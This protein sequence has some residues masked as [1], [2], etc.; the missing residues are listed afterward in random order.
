MWRNKNLP[1]FGPLQ[2]V[3]VVHATFSLAGPFAAQMLAD[4][5]ADVIW[6][7]NPLIPDVQRGVPNHTAE[8]ERRNQR[9]IALNIPSELGKNVFLKLLEGAAVFIENSK[10]GQYVRWGLSDEVLWQVNPSLVIC[11]ISGFGQTG[12][13]DYVH[14]ASFDSIAQAFSG[15]MD[16]NTEEGEVPRVIGPYQGDYTTG[17]FAV[18]GILAAL[19]RV[20]QTGK[21][22]S[23]DLAQYEALM[24]TQWEAIEAL[25]F[26]IKPVKASTPDHLVGIGAYLCQDGRYIELSIVGAAI[27]KKACLLIGVPYGTDTFPEG[28]PMVY[29]HSPAEQV[30]L[31]KLNAFLAARSAAQAESEFLAAG[32]AATQVNCIADLKDNP[33]IVARG[34]IEHIT[35][36]KG[37]E[38]D[39]VGTVPRFAKNPC[40]TWRP[41]PYIGMDNEEILTELGFGPDEIAQL[42]DKRVVVNDEDMRIF[43]P[44]DR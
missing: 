19:Y 5:G 33:H 16:V 41:M 8:S 40:H 10:G 43:Y 18:M 32:I 38:L 12:E 24:R 7:E 20:C 22:E 15:Y 21:G 6:I 34:V 35:S 1:V 26:G 36:L 39:F 44:F 9:S 37:D 11:H 17:C 2:G 25:S 4:Y 3:K 14:R 28:V 23:I 30:F 42:Y 31:T 29:R 13:V 27:V